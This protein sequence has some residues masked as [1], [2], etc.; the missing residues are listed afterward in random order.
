MFNTKHLSAVAVAFAATL[1]AISAS[2]HAQSSD[3]DVLRD[4]IDMLIS[5]H[6]AT[7]EGAPIA[8]LALIDELYARRNYEPG[9]TDPGLSLIHI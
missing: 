4:R 9:W 2:V 7:V 3:R 8:A 5:T 1:L 6:D